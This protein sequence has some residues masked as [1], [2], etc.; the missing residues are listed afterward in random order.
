MNISSWK[1]RT[2]LAAGFGVVCALLVVIVLIG[3]TSMARIY[4]GST[5]IVDEHVPTLDA[6]HTILNQ[7]D[8]V[9]IALYN[10]MLN[11]D[12]TDHQKQLETIAQ[13]RQVIDKNIE[14]LEQ[15]ETQGEGKAALQS[16]KDTRAKYLAGHDALMALIT[17]GKADEARNYLGSKLRPILEAY[18]AAV[19]NMSGLQRQALALTETDP[20]LLT[21]I[22]PLTL[23]GA[24]GM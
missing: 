16:I 12:A 11:P 15:I 21:G 9:A 2:R 3:L 20:P 23:A 7:T 24:A 14:L 19:S 6:S 1:V 17:A 5:E 13:S 8:I 18:K 22:D 10:V 4:H